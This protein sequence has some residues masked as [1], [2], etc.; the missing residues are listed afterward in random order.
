[1]KLEDYQKLYNKLEISEEMDERI[2]AGIL[3]KE[4]G[5]KKIKKNKRYLIQTACAATVAITAIVVLNTPSIATASKHFI[6]KFTNSYI[7]QTEK[8]KNTAIEMQGNYLRINANAKKKDCKM[9]SIMMAEKELGVTLLK[10]KDAYEEKNCILYHPS[11]S[12]SGELYKVELQ[13]DFYVL[14]DIKDVETEV[15]SQTDTVNN[16]RF[17]EGKKFKSPIKVEITVRADYDKNVDDAVYAGDSENLLDEDEV[18]LYEI[19]S[20]G[21]KAVMSTFETSGIWFDYDYNSVNRK[22]VNAVFVY[23]GIEYR[24][25]GAVSQDVFKEFLESLAE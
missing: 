7:L 20:L 22:C 25:V 2:R 11:V 13:D 17:H 15:F 5:K 21:V 3:E 1:M 14:G 19:K 24:Y 8:G 23:K 9:D 6:A 12:K 4:T 16:I 10:S 18:D